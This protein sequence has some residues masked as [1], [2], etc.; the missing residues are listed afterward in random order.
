MAAGMGK[1]L[2]TLCWSVCLLALEE[3]ISE[4]Q[5]LGITSIRFS[6]CP[7]PDNGQDSQQELRKDNVWWV[8]HA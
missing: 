4:N 1:W 2:K 3:V 8:Y 5:T 7:D 6:E